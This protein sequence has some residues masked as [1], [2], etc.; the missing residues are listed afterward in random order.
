[1]VAVAP[2]ATIPIPPKVVERPPECVSCPPP[3]YPPAAESYGLEG[4]VEIEI[5]LDA[6]GH[7]TATRVLSGH[8]AFRAAAQKAVRAWQF[9]PATRDG[10]P[11]E[12]VL[13][14]IVE[15]RQNPRR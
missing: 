15:F 2:P 10:V 14:K 9:V 3:P 7:V 11:V 12:Y 5:K 6:K 13:T 1:M 4:H 8:I